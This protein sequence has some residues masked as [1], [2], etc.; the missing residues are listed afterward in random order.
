MRSK[1][2]ARTL[3][4][5][6]WLVVCAAPE[7]LPSEA[8]SGICEVKVVE[9]PILTFEGV[10]EA[11]P[12]GAGG[13]GIPGELTAAQVE[14]LWKA[15]G[16]K[17]ARVVFS[18]EVAASAGKRSSWRAGGTHRYLADYNVCGNKV[19]SATREV[20][21]GWTV[22][23]EPRFIGSRLV[24]AA[25]VEHAELVEGK[26]S[27]MTPHGP[28]ETPIL[29]VRSIQTA[30]AAPARGVVVLGLIPSGTGGAGA[31]AQPNVQVVL[32][33]TELPRSIPKAPPVPAQRRQQQAQRVRTVRMMPK[34]VFASIKVISMPDDLL[35]SVRSDAGD[36]AVG[37]EITPEQLA[38]IAEAVGA[39]KA[40]IL[41]AGALA[42]V[43]GGGGGGQVFSGE[44]RYYL[45]GYHLVTVKAAG[46]GG[47][48]AGALTA[49]VVDPVASEVR[50]GFSLGLSDRLWPVPLREGRSVVMPDRMGE[51]TLA[52]TSQLRPMEMRSLDGPHGKVQM[53]L[54]RSIKV[55]APVAR[56]ARG[57]YLLGGSTA[58]GAKAGVKRVVLV[59]IESDK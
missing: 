37:S 50:S 46:E 32:L 35:D 1:R 16:E 17:K 27:V 3:V 13:G 21:L 12:G 43:R 59:E 29:S 49:T 34:A 41:E 22:E 47:A 54:V 18:A 11:A 55:V 19:S 39:G 33:R 23:V 9:C 51:L 8:W 36:S 44:H 28:V 56:G 48:E 7:A 25:R 15:V 38:R 58:A 10:R 52:C 30:A 26:A 5:V 20:S 24:V 45:S 57:A 2:L 40:R 14:L 4:L 31:A 53:P 42:F 6:G